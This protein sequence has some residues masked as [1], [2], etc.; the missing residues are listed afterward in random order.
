[1]FR[2]FLAEEYIKITDNLP[3][4]EEWKFEGL[5]LMCCCATLKKYYQY[6]CKIGS[7]EFDRGGTA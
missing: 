5:N 4:D 1:M 2:E 7:V 6:I 3:R